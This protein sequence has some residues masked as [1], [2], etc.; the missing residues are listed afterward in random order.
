ME[1]Q[2]EHTDTFGG[3][4]N[5]CWV[6]RALLQLPENA[7]RRQIV[8]RAK[9]WA[10]LTGERCDVSDYGDTI[11]IRPRRIC[12]VVFVTWHDEGATGKWEGEV[13]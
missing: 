13:I 12:H 2:L 3:E 11:D 5:Y 8:R 7:T 10:G 9:A 6:R 1:Y 4:A